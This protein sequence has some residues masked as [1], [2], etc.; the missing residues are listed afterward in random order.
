[1]NQV[2]A[3]PISKAAAVRL[4]EAHFERGEFALSPPNTP[5][6]L[7]REAATEIGHKYNVPIE[8]RTDPETDRAIVRANRGFPLGIQ[9][10][11]EQAKEW[12]VNHPS[13]R[14]DQRVWIEVHSRG[15][16]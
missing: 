5:S 11:S 2:T 9:A 3:L 8:V 15:R 16:C 13:W 1:M 4:V 6:V 12:M 14:E 10:Y 7:W